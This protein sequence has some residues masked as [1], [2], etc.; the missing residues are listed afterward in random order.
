MSWISSLSGWPDPFL[1]GVENLDRWVT[2]P[3]SERGR[4]GTSGLPAV[5]GDTAEEERISQF[6]GHL[7]AS[8]NA[9]HTNFAH[10]D[11]RQRLNWVAPWQG[12][13][14]TGRPSVPDALAEPVTG[15]ETRLANATDE[16]VVI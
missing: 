13:D 3:L 4:L 1:G 10:F 9:A 5:L 11:G 14:L 7:R 16:A 15:S 12:A 6:I 8:L 2:R